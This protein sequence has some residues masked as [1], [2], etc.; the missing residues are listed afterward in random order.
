MSLRLGE[1]K[2]VMIRVMLPQ[3]LQI[4]ASCPR[5]VQVDVAMS[6]AGFVSGAISNLIRDMI[7][8]AALAFL[9]LVMFLRD[10][11]YPV[12]IALAIPN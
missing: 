3:H 12:A 7:L 10:P 2:S 5:E 4:L 6:Q 11:R 9:V 8:G 1:G